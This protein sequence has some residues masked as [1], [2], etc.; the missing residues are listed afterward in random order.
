MATIK[1][2]QKSIPGGYRYFEP[3]TKWEPRPYSSLDSIVTQLISHRQ[4]R[5]D[6]IAKLGWSLDPVQLLQEVVQYNVA[7][8]VRN[9]WRDYITGDENSHPFQP[10][11]RVVD[12][13]RAVAGGGSVIIEWISEGSPTVSQE[14]AN[15]RAGTCAAMIPDKDNPGQFLKCP[16]NG[17][18]GWEAYF[19]TPVSNAIR[20]EIGRKKEMKLETPFDDKLGSCEGCLCPMPLK[21][22]MPI[23]N[24]I[25]KMPKEQFNALHEKCWIREESK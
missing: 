12:K 15:K 24:I 9:G 1:E 19:T 6:L 4:G 14:L 22:W 10:P 21:V 18:G 13:L 23:K 25:E 5:P 8:C 17:T 11:R 2:P 3:A 20:R 7:V 16:L